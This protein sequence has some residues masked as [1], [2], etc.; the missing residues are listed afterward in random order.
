LKEVMFSGKVLKETD[1]NHLNQINLEEEID[2]NMKGKFK[3]FGHIGLALFLISALVLSLAPVAQA[4]TAVTTV[5]VQFTQ[6]TYNK[7]NT[8]SDFTIHFTPTT[9]LSRG[10]D[11]ITVW[12]PDGDTTM[13]PDSFDLSGAATTASL[14]DVDPDGE[15]VTTSAYDCTSAA[16]LSTTGYRITVTTPVDLAAGTPCSL[17]IEAAAGVA[18][19]DDTSHSPYYLKVYTSQDT[20]PV[21]SDA[22]DID[23]TSP[24]SAVLALTPATAGSAGQ[25]SFTLTLANSVAIGGTASF[26]F[27]YGTTV[28]SSI[29][30]DKIKVSTDAGVTYEDCTVD[31]TVNQKAR[32]VTI[33]T[34]V[35]LGADGENIVRF[36]S[37]AGILNPTTATSYTD[38]YAFTSVDELQ[39]AETSGYS[40][41]AN[42][43][44]KI[45][46]DNDAISNYSDDATMI[47]MYSD[48]LYVQVQ[49][50]YGNLK[51][52]DTEPTISFTSSA[53]TGIFYDTDYSQISSKATTSGAV[54]V[55]Y[56]DSVAGTVTITAA[57]TG[58]TSGTWTMTIT[59]GISVYDSNDNLIKT[60]YPASTNTTIKEADGYH[61]GDYVNDAIGASVT[62]DTVKLGDGIYEVDTVISVSKKITVTSVNGASS[63]TIRNTAEI[64]KAMEVTTDGT[65]AAPIVI[66]DLTFQRLRSAVD[67]DMAIRNAGNDY[68]TVQDCIFNY[69]QPD[70]NSASEGVVWFTNSDTITSATIQNNTFNNCVTTW[71]DMG[72][73]AKSGCIIM[74][75]QA[76]GGTS[77]IS[78]VTISGNTLTD[79]GQYGITFGGNSSN[80]ASGTISN[81]TITN[82]QSPID[83]C[84]YI[85]SLSITGNTITS[86]YNYG[87][88]IE[89]THNASVTVKNNTI[90]GC[91][92]TSGAIRVEEDG[93][94]VTVQYNS[95]TGTNSSGYAIRSTGGTTD[96]KYNWYGSD[97]GP[98]YTALTG[99]TITKSNPNGT[100]D[101]VSDKVTYYPWLHDTLAEVVADNASYQ[102]SNIKLVSGWNT[103]S[104]PVK[105][106]SAADT[107][108]E[109]IPSGMTIGYYYDGGAWNQITSGYTLSPCD[110]VYVR[111]SAETYVL[112]KF[113]A[114]AFSNP[115]KSLDAGWNLISLASLDS[116]KNV[117]NTMACV[118]LTTAGLPGWSQVISPSMN[119]AQT[120]IYGAAETAWAESAGENADK[121]M[122]PGLGYWC[123]MQNAA[124]LAGFEI[125]PIVPDLD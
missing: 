15:V 19:A 11:T 16:V 13:G 116:S 90:T 41:T 74:D 88:L 55:Y 92:G 17:R 75:G 118:D 23:A 53:G 89:G 76:F 18:C 42:T 72:G 68:V 96:G 73:G 39:I 109:L 54:S 25:Y 21:L 22:F 123:Y 47:N 110:A 95:I 115:S 62:G 122:Q 78:G 70:Q 27:P 33:T 6:S 80:S 100:G 119:A 113:D 120:D 102:A 50:T 108:D 86:P 24:T 91:A 111:M 99:A 63:T 57:A 49:D 8:A 98:E 84:D 85:T 43:A 5:W 14:Y 81:N 107:I 97:T 45:G 69:I 2:R 46:F 106:V 34:P 35:E 67:I 44:T 40:I 71:P 125:T 60:Y 117:D 10:V 51:D 94:T 114:S 121:T 31:A 124:T 1:D 93:G 3:F 37:G 101:A 104:T 29:A 112:F 79:C 64:D 32:M 58:Y 4:A 7:T 20:T 59:P 87:M 56:R 65:A 12:F 77:A 66:E 83:V 26:I 38:C 52:P 61:G 48:V 28:P 105:L 9:S 36:T 30:A 103:L 82:G